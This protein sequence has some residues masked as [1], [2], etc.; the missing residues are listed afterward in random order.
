[1]REDTL[2]KETGVEKDF[3]LEIETSVEKLSWEFYQNLM[4]DL[5]ESENSIRENKD[6][7]PEYKNRK[8][9]LSKK[10]SSWFKA[11][12]GKHQQVKFV[13]GDYLNI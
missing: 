12:G 7:D 3:V 6:L 2:I 10:K 8:L 1:M 5:K 11:E 9:G 4:K 13:F